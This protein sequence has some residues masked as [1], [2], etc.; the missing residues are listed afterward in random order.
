[1][2]AGTGAMLSRIEALTH[3]VG[4]LRDA[5]DAHRLAV[6]D[7]TIAVG[8]LHALLVGRFQDAPQTPAV[9]S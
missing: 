7:H 2:T 5:L 6:E 1:M 8:Q 3:T 4:E 9:E